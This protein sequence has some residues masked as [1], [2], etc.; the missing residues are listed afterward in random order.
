MFVHCI[1][2]NQLSIG[3]NPD[4]SSCGNK[5]DNNVIGSCN[6]KSY[7]S[8]AKRT[9]CSNKLWKQ[10]AVWWRNIY[11][12]LFTSISTWKEYNILQMFFRSFSFPSAFFCVIYPS[13]LAITCWSFQFILNYYS[14]PA[15]TSEFAIKHNSIHLLFP[16]RRIAL[17]ITHVLLN[18][19][20]STHIMNESLKHI[21]LSLKSSSSSARSAIKQIPQTD[22][23]TI[24]MD[25]PVPGN[26]KRENV[27][28][29][30]HIKQ[31]RRGGRRI[32]SW[33]WK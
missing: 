7:E 32:S 19:Y 26:S 23:Q 15:H 12:L 6:A 17:S 14:S 28:S 10:I 8:K 3:P 1:I 30:D 4:G 29:N 33:Q 25:Y 5:L 31:S 27:F 13:P 11:S 20:P 24:R 16:P 21:N 22:G 2:W 9:F 18:I